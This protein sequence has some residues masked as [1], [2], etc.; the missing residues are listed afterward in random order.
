M[1]LSRKRKSSCLSFQLEADA[2]KSIQVVKN[3]DTPD[4]NDV[5]NV[6]TDVPHPSAKHVYLK[7]RK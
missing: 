5:N 1:A 7:R 3:T 6:D 2:K 4:S